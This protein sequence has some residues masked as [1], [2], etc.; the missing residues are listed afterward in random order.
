MSRDSP[1]IKE[2]FNDLLPDGVVGERRHAV[3]DLP[4][5]V[6][7]NHRQRA[8]MTRRYSREVTS[9]QTS[10]K[11]ELTEGLITTPAPLRGVCV[12]VCVDMLYLPNVSAVALAQLARVALYCPL[13][14]TMHHSGPRAGSCLVP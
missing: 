14:P 10:L 13:V 2:R 8:V 7:R 5:A 1:L 6:E 4:A 3:Q 9:T 11:G 12:C